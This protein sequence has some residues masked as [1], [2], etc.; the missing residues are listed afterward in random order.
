LVERGDGGKSGWFSKPNEYR[1]KRE[2]RFSL[3]SAK[4]RGAAGE[5][6]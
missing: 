3:V 2:V 5:V 1:G 6:L 4:E